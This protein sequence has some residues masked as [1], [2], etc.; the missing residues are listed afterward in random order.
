[1]RAVLYTHDMIPITVMDVPREWMKFL[2]ERGCLWL[3]VRPSFGL[4]APDDSI[5]AKMFDIRK[6]CITIEPFIRRGQRHW[7]L[8]TQDEEAALLLKST[9]LPG[10]HKE[11]MAR[12]DAAFAKGFWTAIQY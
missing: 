8:F 1:M 11:V 2:E 4:V 6:V 5:T 10:Q 12:E 7:M 9:F 3:A